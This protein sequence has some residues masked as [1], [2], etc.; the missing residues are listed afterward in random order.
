[1]LKIG[2][3]NCRKVSSCRKPSPF[4]QAQNM[5]QDDYADYWYFARCVTNNL[6]SKH[7]LVFGAIIGTV[8]IVGQTIDPTTSQWFCGYYGFILANPRPLV[9]PIRM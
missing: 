8:E 9:E 5:T 3:G 4:T 6:A 7:N 2:I 1:M